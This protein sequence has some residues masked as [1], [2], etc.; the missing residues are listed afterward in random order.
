MAETGKPEVAPVANELWQPPSFHTAILDRVRAELNDP[1]TL[2]GL[3][4]D[5]LDARSKLPSYLVGELRRA[6]KR[7]VQLRG[8][9]KDPLLAPRPR[10]LQ[11]V[12]E[13]FGKSTELY[14]TLWAC[15]ESQHRKPV[16][17]VSAVLLQTESSSLLQQTLPD[18]PEETALQA[19]EDLLE[20]AI[21]ASGLSRPRAT[22]AL[23]NRAHHEPEHP[24]R[25]SQS[26][27]E[28]LMNER[29][30]SILEDL[31][32]LPPDDSVWE[33]AEQFVEEVRA[34]TTAKMEERRSRG[35]ELHAALMQLVEEYSDL[36]EMFEVAELGVVDI[37][38]LNIEDLA[39]QKVRLQALRDLLDQYRMADREHNA[40]R[41]LS[42][43]KVIRTQMDDLEAAIQEAFQSIQG[44]VQGE[45]DKGPESPPPE[46]PGSGQALVQKESSTTTE[47]DPSAPQTST[48]CPVEQDQ[49]SGSS[50]SS[51]DVPNILDQDKCGEPLLPES[52]DPNAD[53]F[54]SSPRLEIAE[55]DDALDSWLDSQFPD[56]LDEALDAWLE[57][58]SDDELDALASLPHEEIGSSHVP[59]AAPPPPEP[60]E[61]DL[62]DSAP[63]IDSN[64]EASGPPPAEQTPD[65]PEP[66]APPSAT[67]SSRPGQPDLA[68]LANLARRAIDD[69]SDEA[70][71][72]LL[73]GLLAADDAGGACWLARAR[74]SQGKQV[75]FPSWLL[76]AA[77]GARWLPQRIL[78]LEEEMRELME[79]HQPGP[80][81]SQQLL[82]MA[83]ALRLALSERASAAEGWLHLAET[84]QELPSL[85]SVVEA[86]QSFTHRGMTLTPHALYDVQGLHHL[87]EQT[88]AAAETLA[89]WLVDAPRKT[90]KAHRATKVW[91][92]M[93]DP[94]GLLREAM[95]I[96]AGDRRQQ[97]EKVLQ[98]AEQWTDFS[99]AEQQIR[100]LDHKLGGARDPLTAAPLEQL[101]R[102]IQRTCQMLQDWFQLAQ[103][104]QQST[105]HKAYE[106][107]QVQKLRA[108]LEAVMPEA[109]RELEEMA[110]S[111]QRP[112]L[113]AAALTTSRVLA[114]LCNT[115]SLSFPA[116]ESPT[117]HFIRD[118]WLSEI[119]GRL[120]GALRLR[121]LWIPE[122]PTNDLMLPEDQAWAL[123][124][125]ALAHSLIEGRNL[126]GAL[127][128]A[129]AVE[130]F[131]AC[132]LYLE[133]M[134]EDAASPRLREVQE[135]LDASRERLRKEVGLVADQREQAFVDGYL[136]DELLD[137]PGFAR[138]QDAADSERETLNAQLQALEPDRCENFG[139]ARRVL[140]AIK[141]S[142]EHQLHEGLRRQRE[143]WGLLR[144]RLPVQAPGTAKV[145]AAVEEALANKDL[146]VAQ[147]IMG[148]LEEILDSGQSSFEIAL[149][150]SDRC[151]QVLEE[152]LERSSQLDDW[153]RQNTIAKALILFKQKR[154]FAGLNPSILSQQRL[155]E[156]IGG[157]ESWRAL[158]NLPPF[159]S[160]V[161]GFAA[162]VMSYL[163][164]LFKTPARTAISVS[165]TGTDWALL[166][167]RMSASDL[168]RPIPQFGSQTSGRYPV[169]CVWERPGADTLS[170]RIKDLKLDIHNLIVV[171]LGRMTVRMRRDLTRI[172]RNRGLAILLV[173]EILFLFL[174]GQLENRLAAFL[175]CAAP[176]AMLNPYTPNQ[177]GNVP[178][179]MFF[180]R[181]KLVREL[182][183]PEGSCLVFGG[184]QL[185]KSALLRQAERQF[186]DPD[187]DRFALV[188]DIRVV[189]HEHG[190]DL[191]VIWRRLRDALVRK[192]FLTTQQT[193]L[194]RPDHIAKAIQDGLEERPGA[195]ILA[196]L[197]EADSFL[198]ADASRGFQTVNQLKSLMADTGYRFKVLLAGLH[199][200]QRFQSIPNQ[201][202]A[203]LGRP[204]LIGPLEARDAYKLVEQPLSALGFRFRDHAPAL[205]ILSYT[206]YHAGLIQLFC[207][208]LVHL[209]QS[210]LGSEPPW[211]IEKQD[212][213][214]VYRRLQPDIASRFNWTLALDR[215]YEMLALIL[216]TE[217][218]DDGSG[219]ARAYPHSDLL[220]MARAWW[221]QGFA[222]L[223]I[224]EFRGLLDE[225]V[226]LGVLVRNTQGHYRLRSPNIVRLM[227]TQADIETRLEELMQAEAVDRLEPEE[228]RAQLPSRQ[229]T[230]PLLSPLTRAQER[231]LS[232]ARSGVGMVFASE[233]LGLKHVEAAVQSLIP[234]DLGDQG[235]FLTIPRNG[236]KPKNL[237]PWVRDQLTR[238]KVVERA[239][240]LRQVDRLEP[241]ELL[242]AIAFCNRYDKR[243]VR[244]VYVLHPAATRDWLRLPD[245]TRKT[246]ND[247]LEA[248][249]W[250]R[251]YSAKALRHRLIDADMVADDEVCR[252][253]MEATGGWPHLVE[254]LFSRTG[255]TTDIRPE[256]RRLLTELSTPPLSEEFLEM[257]GV[258]RQSPG[259]KLLEAL[260][261][262][263]PLNREYLTPD[264][265][266][267]G[268][269]ITPEQCDQWLDFLLRMG[270]L[271]EGEDDQ[272]ALEP[273]LARLL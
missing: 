168:A 61:T 9:S 182:Q 18:G 118:K 241:E 108:S 29:L 1:V 248:A 45:T 203:H 251:R 232:P 189:G 257:L 149:G 158:R 206:N 10:L 198:D 111:N 110:G 42:A 170:A 119:A 33:E 145:Q 177:A 74:E 250:L 161:A 78:G 229:R 116:Q 239:L 183:L 72:T 193:R 58:Q 136:N 178:P 270:C 211:F 6:L 135:R 154:N 19:W 133:A 126:E 237:A 137:L 100:R 27:I 94:G 95:E 207:R 130:D 34:L 51:N 39:V 176:Y 253:L 191:E 8:F 50:L 71:N 174:A 80:D 222:S 141:A 76:K 247:G 125:Q 57:S 230:A 98:I 208:E 68:D 48:D 20:M 113:Q 228:I 249:V 25:H 138:T 21:S 64:P 121:L 65:A 200:V 101:H 217:Q 150:N 54:F 254:L 142:L 159:S 185:G 85:A 234:A 215:R 236:A 220:R 24:H 166:D 227:G 147:E 214:E 31:R 88:A 60:N 87:E 91:K 4:G 22:W 36:V 175:R 172:S 269:E 132:R 167:A 184:R 12:T 23:F 261:H 17:T 148:R 209:L 244:I 195:R 105:N 171:Y 99:Y 204:V 96:A 14:A 93:V 82:G 56:G 242:E 106:V 128:K 210:R 223:Q 258:P 235:L 120:E 157:L 156:A 152:F 75:A 263:G 62:R 143:T 231:L 205:R 107:Q 73:C 265:V 92:K 192:G 38:D 218:L 252:L 35:R 225:M 256:A 59:E 63:H 216:I 83:A 187:R 224:D 233:A 264:L 103:A 30:R 66:T 11:A 124:P 3:V 260:A 109:A 212:V 238:R 46:G 55:T 127:A 84:R 123:L 40:S 186:H 139:P 219:Y 13:A 47:P 165:Q 131:R 155:D 246:L 197:D 77:Q 52:L 49:G 268:S 104:Q 79:A 179:E 262:E 196:M 226:G 272:V 89:R 180:G 32:K 70:W 273:L 41:T 221:P 122:V 86:V 240:F 267:L 255:R 169:L 90:M 151:P 16:D 53:P 28:K 213:E 146:R 140:E 181:E 102:E 201:P 115:L 2:R 43:R 117:Q 112:D 266:D 26:Q 129:L 153:V 202:L 69:N 97:A 5:V 245:P 67:L 7:S 190:G 15:W 144:H 164:F 271:D 188:E 160:E 81:L 173:D 134:D 194:T 259:W 243:Q 114:E 44:W 162:S 199:N 37:E 163:G